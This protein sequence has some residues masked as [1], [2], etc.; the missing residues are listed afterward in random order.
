MCNQAVAIANRLPV[1]SRHALI[2][3][4]DRVRSISHKLGMALATT[5]NSIY[6]EVH[7]AKADQFLVVRKNLF[8]RRYATS[9]GPKTRSA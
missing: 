1:G 2:V 7:E 8:R 6:R 3:R 5:W 9:Y 4:L